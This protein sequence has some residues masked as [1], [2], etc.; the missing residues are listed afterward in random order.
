MSARCLWRDVHVYD[1]AT[2]NYL[3]GV[4]QTGSITCTA[5]NSMLHILLVTTDD[6][7]IRQNSTGNIMTPS[8]DLVIPGDYEVINEGEVLLV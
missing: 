4:C 8:E 6:F 7:S 1:A 5:F 2:R 3:G